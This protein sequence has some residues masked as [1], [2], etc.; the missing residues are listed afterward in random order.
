MQNRRN[1]VK[2]TALTAAMAVAGLTSFSA[3]AADTIK[4]GILHSLSG[5]MAISET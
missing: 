5:T 2:A 1:F 3:L 4:V